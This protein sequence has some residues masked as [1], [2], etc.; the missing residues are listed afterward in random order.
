MYQNITFIGRTTSNARL[1]F[2]SKG[3]PV[4]NFDL[5]INRSGNPT[6]ADFI[7]CVVWKEKAKEFTD[8]F[9]KGSLILLEGEFRSTPISLDDGQI[10]NELKFEVHFFKQM[11]KPKPVNNEVSE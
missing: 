11:E 1:N 5:A 10:K 8:K 7:P 4:A 6:K 9:G 2:T 3:T